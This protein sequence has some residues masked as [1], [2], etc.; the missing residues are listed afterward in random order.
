MNGALYTAAASVFVFACS[1]VYA[2]LVRRQDGRRAD[3]K[4]IQELFSMLANL[5][6]KTALW[7]QNLAIEE[8]AEFKNHEDVVKRLAEQTISH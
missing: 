8:L 5:D 3:W 7:N 6:Y 2:A 1:T 4:R